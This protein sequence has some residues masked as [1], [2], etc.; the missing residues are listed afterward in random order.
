[1][2]KVLLVSVA[3]IDEEAEI[4]EDSLKEL[5][6]LG[7]TCGYEIQGQIIQRR[8]KYNPKYLIGLG[9][10]QQLTEFIN[11]NQIELV[12]FDQELSPT[13]NR[14]L[15]KNLQVAVADRT[16]VILQI[17][18]Q[19]AKTKEAKTQVEIASLEY[20][21][22]RLTGK[23]LHLARQRG[24]KGGLYG[25]G[26][27]EKQI[28]IDRRMIRDR[29]SKL[30]RDFQ[31]ITKER[32]IQREARKNI[33]KV[34]LVGYTNAG[35]TELMNALTKTEFVAD[36]NL[37]V[38]LD[39]KIRTLNPGTRPKI[40]LSDTVGF[41]RN[42]PLSLIEA[43]KS[44]LEEVCRADLILLIID[45][46][47]PHYLKQ[48]DVS[49]RVLAEIGADTIPTIYVYNKIDLLSDE[50]R[51]LP[52]IMENADKTAISLSALNAEDAVRLREHIYSCFEQEMVTFEVRYLYSQ[53]DGIAFVNKS[54]KITGTKSDNT[55]IVITAKTTRAN[56]V[57]IK[58]LGGEVHELS[59]RP[60]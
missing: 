9:K 33:L 42:L 47:N 6:L 7:A 58:Q 39:T 18:N 16:A 50:D 40:L 17:F 41:I 55:G 28:E 32:L 23:W 30:K 8:K 60:Y 3:L 53:G 56:L 31:T 19:H 21:L 22:T 57:K 29:I 20:A 10:I 44:T 48:A 43:F 27:G 52:K 13:Q 34:A 38:T 24:G 54:C 15:E 2:E 4:I 11:E 14:N 49:E 51:H 46:S 59:K 12:L 26:M 5:A 1:M 25:K 37:F 45:F 35:K 36:D